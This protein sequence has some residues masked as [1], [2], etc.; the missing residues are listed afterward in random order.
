MAKIAKTNNG[1]PLAKPSH[2]EIAKHAYEIY[3]RNG[4]Q[5]GREIENWLAAEAELMAA[6]RKQEAERH[7]PRATPTSSPPPI[8]RRQPPLAAA[9][10]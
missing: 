5:P 1:G 2:E 8:L 3:E 10:S 6:A 7:H 4:C 9:R